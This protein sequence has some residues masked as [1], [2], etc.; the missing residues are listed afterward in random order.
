MSLK[1]L[2]CSSDDASLRHQSIL[3]AI[4]PL[5]PYKIKSACLGVCHPLSGDDGTGR[6]T[7]CAAPGGHLHRH[8]LWSAIV[9]M[10]SLAG[11][12][13]LYLF[14]CRLSIFLTADHQKLNLPISQ[15]ILVALVVLMPQHM[16]V[17]LSFLSFQGLQESWRI[18]VEYCYA[19]FALSW[20]S[21]TCGHTF[22]T[23]FV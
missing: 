5:N 6:K 15:N 16:V 7:L 11:D 9:M 1:V 4:H 17:L 13:R 12:V 2:L 8:W 20:Y 19:N 18:S 23:F 3:R 22:P 10:S 21:Y 14:L